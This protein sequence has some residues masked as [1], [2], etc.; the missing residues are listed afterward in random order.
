MVKITLKVSLISN[1][2]SSMTVTFTHLLSV[3]V[4]SVEKVNLDVRDA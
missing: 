2:S 4:D 3:L 1:A